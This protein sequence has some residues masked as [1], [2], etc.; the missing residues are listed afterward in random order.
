M[1]TLTAAL[2]TIVGTAYISAELTA[3]ITTSLLYASGLR[4]ETVAD[5]D[6][7]NS[8]M[9]VA[10]FAAEILYNNKLHV[11]ALSD[12]TVVPRS[13]DDM[14]SD[15]MN[16]LLFTDIAE[17]SISVKNQPPSQFQPGVRWQDGFN[18]TT[19]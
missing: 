12:N 18:G 1:T 6:S 10:L 16:N 3:A 2:D 13:L 11:Q 14:W 8:D 19:R 17:K 5:G 4:H 7:D 15:I 9:A